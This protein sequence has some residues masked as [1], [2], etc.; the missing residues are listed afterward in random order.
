VGIPRWVALAIVVGAS[1]C[2]RIGFD[3]TGDGDDGGDDGVPCTTWDAFD[4]PVNLGPEIN[5]NADDSG[6]APSTD[7]RTMYFDSTRQGGV[8]NRD[9][10]VA[11]RTEVEAP[12]AAPINLAAFNTTSL[13]ITP[14]LSADGT[15]F[16]FA[17]NAG[18]NN[19][20]DLS[21]ASRTGVTTFAPA[22]PIAMLSSDAVDESGPD[23]SADGTTMYYARSDPQSAEPDIAVAVRTTPDAPFEQTDT[24]LVDAVNQPTT[25][26]RNPTISPDGLELYFES[27]RG[28]G[29]RI[30]V[31]TRTSADQPFGPPADVAELNSVGNS[32]KDPAL[33]ADGR[34]IY[35]ASNRNGTE[36]GLDLWAARRGCA[37]TTVR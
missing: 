5:S 30:Y 2:G 14:W 13:D 8:G 20:Y 24:T 19:S 10:W 3:P 25:I 27:D 1:A 28:N 21:I 6:P 29:N 4:A 31:A 32:N 37:V 22:T 18:E 34:T 11:T 7:E 23:V 33:S 36:G 17:T 35:F 16:V 15:Q 9:L 12:F 26:E